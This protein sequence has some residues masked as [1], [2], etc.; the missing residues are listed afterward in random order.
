M[1]V[2]FTLS[3]SSLDHFDR[4][5]LFA[6]AWERSDGTF[7]VRFGGTTA[8]KSDGDAIESSCVTALEVRLDG[9]RNEPIVSVVD[10]APRM[11]VIYGRIEP[12][13][14]RGEFTAPCPGKETT[15]VFIDNA[16]RVNEND[17][18]APRAIV[19]FSDVDVAAGR[20]AGH[21]R[22]DPGA[23]VANRYLLFPIL[24]GYFVFSGIE[25][26]SGEPPPDSE[27]P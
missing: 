7:H 15:V 1:R 14:L 25:K 27:L 22:V 5:T 2:R 24:E 12:G 3:Q 21:L 19:E 8:L 26:H 17:A 6:R 20:L 4:E 11:Q 10:D 23:L 18:L 16:W 9:F 13:R